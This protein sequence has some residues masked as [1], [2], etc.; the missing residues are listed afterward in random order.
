[1]IFSR[2]LEV[3]ST[4][5]VGRLFTAQL[6]MVVALAIDSLPGTVDHDTLRNISERDKAGRGM[7]RLRISLL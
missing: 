3:V 6:T 4:M 2:D 5:L 1:M 7:V